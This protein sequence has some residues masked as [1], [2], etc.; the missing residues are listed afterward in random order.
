[1]E[2]QL[3]VDPTDGDDL[4]TRVKIETGFA[5]HHGQ[6]GEPCRRE[7]DETPGNIIWYKKRRRKK[8]KEQQPLEQECKILK[9][10]KGFKGTRST[11]RRRNYN[12]Q[13]K[14]NNR[15]IKNRRHK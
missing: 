13:L 3:T 11:C 6:L 9:R 2:A 8:Q 14:I 1:M 15:Q 7:D 4:Q 5:M 10:K 12:K